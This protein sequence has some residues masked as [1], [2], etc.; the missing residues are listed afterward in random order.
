MFTSLLKDIVK[1]TNEEPD[2]E[3]HKA[4]SGRVPSTVVSVPV[5]LEVH[6]LPVCR[7]VH[8]PGSSPNTFITEA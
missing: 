3:I 2:D 7:Y 8:Q 4:K 1:D 6:H 5:E